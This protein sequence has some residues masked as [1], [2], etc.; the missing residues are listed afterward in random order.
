MKRISLCTLVV[1]S[2]LSVI[3]LSSSAYAQDNCT[4]DFASAPYLYGGKFTNSRLCLRWSEMKFT[5][6]FAS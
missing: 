6:M 3:L 4:D 5:R 1:I 2:S